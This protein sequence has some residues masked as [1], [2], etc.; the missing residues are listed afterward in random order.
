MT[1]YIRFAILPCLAFSFLS[2]TVFA[3]RPLPS[4]AEVN[5]LLETYDDMWRGTS[6]KATVTMNIKT[7]NWERSLQ[8]DTWSLGKD[9]TFVKV[10]KPLKERDSATL[11]VKKEVYNYL[12]ATD[13]TIKITSA[14]MMGA[15]MGSHL[16]N[17]DLVR[18]S[19]MS[20]DYFAKATFT[21]VRDGVDV[22]EITCTPKPDA[23][24]VWGKVIAT[25]RNSDR[26]PI[27]LVFFDEDGKK[28]R[29]MSLSGQKIV[30]GK[31]IPTIMTIIPEDKPGEY[32][33]LKYDSIKFG[34]KLTEDFFSLNQLR[35]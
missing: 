13:R 31:N 27:K 18:D 17:D 16:T 8:M 9:F 7:A 24:V 6:S 19:R 14:M 25:Y 33:E 11:K 26:Q 20:D 32:T 23:P 30:S 1:Q 3:E 12:P 34:I 5:K 2:G 4:V 21:G 29:T 35:R 28:V 22:T 10:L 15:W